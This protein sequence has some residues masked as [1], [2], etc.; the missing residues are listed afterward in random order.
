MVRNAVL[1]LTALTFVAADGPP[2]G[3]PAAKRYPQPV[4]VGDV[5]GRTVLEPVEAQPVLGRVRAVVRRPDGA[6]A[7]V[8]S[9]G[10]LLGVG[11]RTVAV[12]LHATALLGEYVALMDLTPEQLHALPTAVPEAALPSDTMI[13]MGLVRPFH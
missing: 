8:V 11:T 10:G 6:L 3:S 12:P 5:V 2:P 7:L 9:E 1:V 13:R 4:S